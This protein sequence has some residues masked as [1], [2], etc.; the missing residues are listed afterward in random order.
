M[1][2]FLPTG[3][4]FAMLS[5]G[6]AQPPRVQT[7]APPAEQAPK[8]RDQFFSGYITALTETE[9]T[10]NRTVLGDKV[11]T[12]TFHI[13]PET[14]VEGKPKV[15]ARVTVQFVPAEDGERAV[16]IIVR[17]TPAKRPADE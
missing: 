5:I 9:I 1:V 13:T 10:V 16:A 2:R 12:R 11:S 4:L 14:K 6:A 17:A 3:F 15:K 8:P 7:P